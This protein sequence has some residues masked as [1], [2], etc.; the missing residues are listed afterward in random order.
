MNVIEHL[1]CPGVLIE[2]AAAYVRIRLSTQETEQIYGF[3]WLTKEAVE[4][5]ILFRACSLLQCS[6][7]DPSLL[8]VRAEI[9]LPNQPKRLYASYVPEDMAFQIVTKQDENHPH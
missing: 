4:D 7:V 2:G 6:C 1:L 8:E 5:G 9:E 3:Y